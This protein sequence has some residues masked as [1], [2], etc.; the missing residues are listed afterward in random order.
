[1][2]LSLS[3]THGLPLSLI[4]QPLLSVPAGPRRQL[5]DPED[6]W[7]AKGPSEWCAGCR[8][9]V[10]LLVLR[11]VLFHENYKNQTKQMLEAPD[12]PMSLN[13]TGKQFK[14]KKSFHW[15]PYSFAQA[16]ELDSFI[17]IREQVET[18]L[19]IKEI[20]LWT[21]V[22]CFLILEI[23]IVSLCVSYGLI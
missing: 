21:Q 9:L 11:F 7:T 6:V 20:T 2:E 4:K 16:A 13:P 14:K 22:L 18:A 19:Q 3:F 17:F 1:M 12:E 10:G 8:D 15:F 5:R 23:F